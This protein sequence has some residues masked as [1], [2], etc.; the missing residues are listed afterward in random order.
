MFL[1]N[2]HFN[3][4]RFEILRNGFQGLDGMTLK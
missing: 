1:G 2:S 3:F 4:V